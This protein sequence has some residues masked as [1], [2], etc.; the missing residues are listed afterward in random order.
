MMDAE[1]SVSTAAIFLTRTFS[2]TISAHPDVSAI[3]THSGSPS[4][5][6]ATVSVTATR[7]M[8]SHDGVSW[9]SGSFVFSDTPTM[10]TT[11]HTAMAMY[12][13]FTASF[14]R[15]SCRGDCPDL[16]SGRHGSFFFFGL[17]AAPDAI[18]SSV[19]SGPLSSSPVALRSAA[20]VPTRVRMPVATTRPRH[21]PAFTLHDENAMLSAVSFSGC[22][23]TRGFTLVDLAT[24][25][26]SPVRSISFT[27]RSFAV[28]QRTSAGTTSPVPSLTRSPRTM[29]LDSTLISSPSRINVEIGA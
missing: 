8:K 29:S 6:A 11:V 7:I 25:S 27:R 13:S 3:V 10:N 1:P 24:S 19:G 9:S 4:G 26:G 18:S 12:P 14:S 22:P 5:M 15:F 17:G 23:G 21:A 16:V 20:I 28:M 2:L